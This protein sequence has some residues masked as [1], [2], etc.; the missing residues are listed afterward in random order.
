MS[1]W[2]GGRIHCFFIFPFYTICFE[3][4]GVIFFEVSIY[5]ITIASIGS[6]V[7]SLVF[8]VF[9]NYLEVFLPSLPALMRP[10]CDKNCEISFCFH[11]RSCV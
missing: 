7:F 3:Y 5:S 1:L 8:C 10:C 2:F 6:G 4:C 11:Q 9:E